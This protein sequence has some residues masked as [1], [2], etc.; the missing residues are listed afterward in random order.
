[1]LQSKERIL[2]ILQDDIEVGGCTVEVVELYYVLVIGEC[3][4]L[5]LPH[6]ILHH[7]LRMLQG[8]RFLSE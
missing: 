7:L 3:K 8:Y 6:Q 4:N 5:D 1:L 2:S